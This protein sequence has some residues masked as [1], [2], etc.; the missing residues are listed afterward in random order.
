MRASHQ[1]VRVC[2]TTNNGMLLDALSISCI[3]T[4]TLRSRCNLAILGAKV[5]LAADGK[6]STYRWNLAI[7]P[8]CRPRRF[9]ISK[10]FRRYLGKLPAPTWIASPKIL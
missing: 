2:G 3:R 9:R 5:L 6:G 10:V 8:F 1:P 4:L 7:G